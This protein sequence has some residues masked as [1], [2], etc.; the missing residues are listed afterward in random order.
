MEFNDLQAPEKISP[1]DGEYQATYQRAMCTQID[2]Y[3]R[4]DGVE[5]SEDCLHLNVYTP[6][7]VIEKKNN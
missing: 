6:H 2:P 1:W 7:S 3:M 5:G 4:K